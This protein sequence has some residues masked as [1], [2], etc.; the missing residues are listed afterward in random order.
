MAVSILDSAGR[1]A[2][3]FLGCTLLAGAPPWAATTHNAQAPIN[4][5]A[6][7]TDFDYR[8]NTLLFRR[9]RISQGTVQ[10]EAQEASAT[11]LEFENSQWTFKG[12]V[13]ITV[14]DGKLASDLATVTFRNNEISR[15]L[16][17]GGPATFEQRL[18]DGR[19]AQG[20]ARSIEYD[21]RAAT[22]RLLGDAWLSDSRNE[23][24]GDTLVYD[25]GRQRV[26]A[27]PDETD[28]GGVRITINP[29]EAKPRTAEPPPKEPAP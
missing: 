18:E 15:A 16:V 20:R 26:A 25:I 13:R 17:Q 4:L 11:G 22:V 28:P 27:N 12:Q 21:V 8:N 23:I 14:P 2:A 1:R 24:R 5:E 3:L 9:V 10:V 6:A 29:Q 7:S 19:L